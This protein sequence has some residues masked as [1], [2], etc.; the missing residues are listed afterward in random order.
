[1][2]NDSM[3]YRFDFFQEEPKEWFYKMSLKFYT[4]LSFD[5]IERS[6]NDYINMSLLIM[7][8]DPRSD[9]AV[10]EIHQL[11]DKITV[12]FKKKY[13]K[14]RKDEWEGDWEDEED[15]IVEAPPIPVYIVI[16]HWDSQK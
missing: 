5:S 6:L 2:S 3:Y 11:H 15:K 12:F 1:M 9:T 13:K 14:E 10:Q 8:I 4:A 16:N 7:S